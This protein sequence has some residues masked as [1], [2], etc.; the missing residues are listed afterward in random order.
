MAF[1]PTSAKGSGR[2]AEVPVL[3]I[4]FNLQDPLSY[5]TGIKKQYELMMH[6]CE[7]N[8][9][10]TLQSNGTQ[11]ILII[12]NTQLLQTEHTTNRIQVL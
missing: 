4:M 7:F 9:I 5:L 1:K 6:C 8:P 10:N 11:N 2:I 3:E 12:L